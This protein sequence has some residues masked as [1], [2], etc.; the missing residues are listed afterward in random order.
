MLLINWSNKI[1]ILL[2]VQWNILSIT[3]IQYE[4]NKNTEQG[5]FVYSIQNENNCVKKLKYIFSCK[6]NE[7]YRSYF[8]MTVEVTHIISI[9]SQAASHLWDWLHDIFNNVILQTEETCATEKDTSII[10]FNSL[11]LWTF[12]MVPKQAPFTLPFTSNCF[13]MMPALRSYPFVVFVICF[14]TFQHS[15][16]N[17]CEVLLNHTWIN[18]KI[19][20]CCFLT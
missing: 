19:R 18:I 2:I 16:W 9:F 11:W 6:K 8:S 17:W 12:F 10:S 7:I 15:P 5:L 1:K 4:W 20:T 14:V 13:E 3:V